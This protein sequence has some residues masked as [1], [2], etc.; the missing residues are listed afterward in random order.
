ME[1][2]FYIS[3]MERLKTRTARLRQLEETLLLK[4]RGMRAADLAR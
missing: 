1:N 3:D 2:L 4:S